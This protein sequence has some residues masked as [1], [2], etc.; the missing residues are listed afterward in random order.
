M[1]LNPKH[2]KG[3]VIDR[4]E[5]NAQQVGDSRTGPQTMHLPEIYFTDGSSISFR[6]EEHPQA[7][8]Y[9]MDIVYSGRPRRKG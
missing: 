3:K 6:V 7:H 4:V 9:G 5:M 8:F 2:L 1:S